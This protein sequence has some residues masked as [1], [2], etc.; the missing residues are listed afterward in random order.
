MW[1]G[2]KSLV[3]IVISSMRFFSLQLWIFLR[4][5]GILFAFLLKCTKIQIFAKR[6]KQVFD[7]IFCQNL[8]EQESLVSSIGRAFDS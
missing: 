3:G 4:N 8:F 1:L 2:N 6:S 5:S 7:M